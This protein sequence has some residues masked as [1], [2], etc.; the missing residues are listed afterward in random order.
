MAPFKDGDKSR[1]ICYNCKEIISTTFITL[2][3]ILVTVCDKCDEIVSVPHQPDKDM[4]K[5]EDRVLKS[6]G[7]NLAEGY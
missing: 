3:G 5:I 4:A 7:V 2:E 1:S 6:R